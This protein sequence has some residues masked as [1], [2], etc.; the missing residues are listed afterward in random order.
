VVRAIVAF[1]GRGSVVNL[2]SLWPVSFAIPLAVAGAT[3]FFVYRHTSR[4][5]K[6]QALVATL[7]VIALTSLA[8]LPLYSLR[9]LT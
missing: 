4:R 8:Y 2:M 7:L 9:R 1:F 5:R 3:G 6:L